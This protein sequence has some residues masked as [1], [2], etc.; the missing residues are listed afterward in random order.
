MKFFK[1]L[2][3]KYCPGLEI[4]LLL[5]FL[6]YLKSGYQYNTQK[7]IFGAPENDYVVLYVEIAGLI[8][9]KLNDYDERKNGIISADIFGNCLNIQQLHPAG[10]KSGKFF[11]RIYRARPHGT[12]NQGAGPA[13][14]QGA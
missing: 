1:I 5:F 12:S 9:N 8:I 11:S 10:A 3:R 2:R 6:T 14:L 7:E 13:D 4:A